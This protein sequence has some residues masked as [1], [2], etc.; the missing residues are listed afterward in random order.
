[1][2][3]DAKSSKEII[4]CF[5]SNTKSHR[6]CIRIDDADTTKGCQRKNMVYDL[7]KNYLNNSMTKSD[8]IKLLGKDEQDR[9]LKIYPNDW[10]AEPQLNCI[11]YITNLCTGEKISFY[12]CFDENNKYKNSEIP[13]LPPFFEYD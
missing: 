3:I 9:L 5:E 4:A 2:S 12:V 7:Q 10:F 6:A 1:V 8:V 11:A 13:S